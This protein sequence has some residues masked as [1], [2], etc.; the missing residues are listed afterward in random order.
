MD[1]WGDQ[2]CK[3][4]GIF[5][6]FVF[7][8]DFF[9]EEEYVIN[10]IFIFDFFKYVDDFVCYICQIYGD[11]FCIG[12]VGYFNFYLDL[13]LEEEDFKWFKVKCDVGV[14]FIVM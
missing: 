7:W 9:R 4:F 10:F 11:Y 1:R 2:R 5:N 3:D 12:V 6:I 8:G 14:D 13:E